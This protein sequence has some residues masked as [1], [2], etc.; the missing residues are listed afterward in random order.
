LA[1][2]RLLTSEDAT[3]LEMDGLREVAVVELEENEVAEDVAVMEIANEVGCGSVEVQLAS[4]G[5][6]NVF[7]S[8]PGCILVDDEVLKQVNSTDGIAVATCR[9]FSYAPA[10]RRV[11]SVKSAPFAVP[12]ARLESLMTMLKNKGP[13]LQA[14]PIRAPR[15]AVLYT[16]PV[17]GE[18]A[19]QLFES[20]MHQ[21]LERL[22]SNVSHALS[23]IEEEQMVAGSLEQ[24]LKTR[25]T[26]VIIA[27]TTAPAAPYDVVGR[28]IVRAG[29][30]IE[31]FLAPVDPG[32]FLLLS[33]QGDI[34]IV[35]A[36]G[37]FRSSKP[38][39]LDLLLPPLLAG[40]HLSAWDIAGLGHGGLLA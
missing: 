9:N 34:P 3:V 17:S 13:V 28:A 5:R 27:S 32:N 6:A 10:G 33:Y 12:K 23:A 25:P 26:L 40:Y 31:G 15:V 22:G 11:S 29:G 1:R 30:Q 8:E 16:D 21:R 35:A 38:N 20:T 39:G 37:C 14:R 2:G 4:G 24:L 18:R 19:S 7:T 36:P